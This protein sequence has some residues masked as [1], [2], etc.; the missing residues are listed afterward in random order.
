M[1]MEDMA[2]LFIIFCLFYFFFRTRG[3]QQQL[4]DKE[5]YIHDL[6]KELDKLRAQERVKN[7]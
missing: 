1:S 7:E 3:L 6:C 5:E 2:N 4:N